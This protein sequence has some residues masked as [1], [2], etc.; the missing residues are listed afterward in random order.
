MYNMQIEITPK[1]VES[2]IQPSCSNLAWLFINNLMIVR[3]RWLSY[4]WVPEVSRSRRPGAE[5]TG[6]RGLGARR[7][8]ASANQQPIG[9]KQLRNNGPTVSYTDRAWHA[10][11]DRCNLHCN[12]IARQVPR[13]CSN[14]T[15][16]RVAWEVHSLHSEMLWSYICDTGWMKHQMHTWRKFFTN[17]K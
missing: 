9:L 14:F 1:A 10:Q 6:A 16:R 8:F 3:V 5:I 12:I 11:N 2:G 13:K 17:H 15:G 7:S 4:P